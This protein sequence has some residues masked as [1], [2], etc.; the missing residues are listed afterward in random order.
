MLG[1]SEGSGET[2]DLSEEDEWD[3]EPPEMCGNLNK[4]TNYIHGWQQRFMAVKVSSCDQHFNGA[5]FDNFLL[6][7]EIHSLDLKSVDV[8]ELISP[9]S[10]CNSYNIQ[11]FGFMSRDVIVIVS[12]SYLPLLFL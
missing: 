5:I 4:W 12:T 1:R 7:Y 2:P 6:G 8:N 3:I 10:R 9:F 11:V